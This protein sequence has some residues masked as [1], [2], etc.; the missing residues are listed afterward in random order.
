MENKK[1]DIYLFLDDSYDYSV[2]MREAIRIMEHVNKLIDKGVQTFE[3]KHF[4][5]LTP[6]DSTAEKFAK[7]VNDYL[8]EEENEN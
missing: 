5:K 7:M 4:K 2:Y 8:N 6:Y 3:G 1:V